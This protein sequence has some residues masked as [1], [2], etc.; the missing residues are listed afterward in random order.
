MGGRR[1]EGGEGR[2]ERGGRRGEGGEGREE[3]GGRRGEGGEE[4]EEKGGRKREGGER[5][6]GKGE[7]PIIKKP[8]KILSM[9]KEERELTD[10]DLQNT[11]AATLPWKLI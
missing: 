11:S 5:K 8:L 6:G 10:L 2:E 9:Y 4:R 7:E 3:K 1:G